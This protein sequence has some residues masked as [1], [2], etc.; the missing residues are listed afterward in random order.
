MGIME[1]SRLMFVIL[2]RILASKGVLNSKDKELLENIP[3]HYTYLEVIDYIK[4]N[5]PVWGE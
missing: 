4:E 1:P 5:F 2:T 3:G